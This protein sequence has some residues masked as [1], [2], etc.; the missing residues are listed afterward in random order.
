ML[1]RITEVQ[2]SR[3]LALDGEVGKVRDAYVGEDSWIVRYLIVDTGSWLSGRRML[4]DPR[5]VALIDRALHTISVSLSRA[6][7][8]SS[9]PIDLDQPVS[10]QH[11]LQ[12]SRYYGYGADWT[13]SMPWAMGPMPSV[14]V[15]FTF[16]APESAAHPS[17]ESASQKC[18]RSVEALLNFTL[19]SADGQVGSIKDGYF[20]DETWTL[21]YLV[22]QTG[23]WLLGRRVLLR[24]DAVRR[25]DW[26]AQTLEVDQTRRQIDES[27]AFDPDH[28]P[29]G[30]LE[31]ALKP[32]PSEGAGTR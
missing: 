6:R 25:V 19:L 24:V 11:E 10:R 22:V 17:A 18:L 15:P 26:T 9:P 12:L 28:P 14:M 20:D 4:I 8:E 21:R 1:R 5:S 27:R 31:S 32:P 7:V 3:M 23:S 2:G 29:P 16:D 30:D 13:R